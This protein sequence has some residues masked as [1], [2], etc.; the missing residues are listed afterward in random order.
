M[1]SGVVE[2]ISNE[3]LDVAHQRAGSRRRRVSA[4]F[5][6]ARRPAA[7]G[8]GRAVARADRRPSGGTAPRSSPARAR[9]RAAAAA[10]SAPGRTRRTA[11]RTTL[12]CLSVPSA[13][14]YSS[15]IRPASTNT[16]SPR[17][18]PSASSTLAKRSV[19]TPQL[20]VGRAPTPP[21]VYRGSATP[22]YRRASWPPAGQLPHRRYSTRPPEGQ[23]APSW[24]PPRR[25]RPACARNQACSEGRRGATLRLARASAPLEPGV[26][27]CSRDARRPSAQPRPSIGAP[28]P[29]PPIDGDRACVVAAIESRSESRQADPRATLLLLQNLKGGLCA[30]ECLLPHRSRR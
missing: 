27:A 7:R 3:S 4:R 16:R 13:A 23:Q 18:T 5:R 28:T 11:D 9:R 24:P 14:T 26:I 12:P 29:Q 10:R 22:P 8:V 25:T 21:R 2:P 30:H 1:S 15:G 6:S 20:D 17:S 19:V